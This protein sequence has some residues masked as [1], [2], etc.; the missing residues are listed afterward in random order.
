MKTEKLYFEDGM[1]DVCSEL[2]NYL[3]NAKCDGLTEIELIEAIPDKQ[4]KS[5]IWCTEKC[6]AVHRSE[7]RKSQCSYFASTV[8]RVCDFRGQLYV[9]GEKVKFQVPEK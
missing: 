4:T 3:F 6:N 8:G 7:C 9:K 5:H 2:E 1:S